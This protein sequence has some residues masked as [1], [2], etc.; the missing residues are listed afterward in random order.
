MEYEPHQ[1]TLLFLNFLLNP[2]YND[3]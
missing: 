1:T 3:L 2:L